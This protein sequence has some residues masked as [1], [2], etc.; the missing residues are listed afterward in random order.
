MI[1]LSLLLSGILLLRI[2]RIFLMSHTFFWHLTRYI[3]FG[4][5]LGYGKPKSLK[6][7][8]VSAKTQCESP[9][10]NKSAPCCRSKC[11]ICPFIEETETFQNKDTSETL[12][13]IK[14]SLNCSSKLVVYLIECKSYSKQHVGG[15]VTLSR[16][17]FEYYK[18]EARRV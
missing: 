2:V 16:T 8:L 3:V 6:D 12:D 7:H 4:D 18:S 15:T 14:W 10:D 1:D 5:N 17:R 9:S 13:I 11:Q